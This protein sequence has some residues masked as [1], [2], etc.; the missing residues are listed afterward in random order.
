MTYTDESM[1]HICIST[2]HTLACWR[3]THL[4]FI[5]HTLTSLHDAYLP[6]EITLTFI[7]AWHTLSTGTHV[8]LYA[9]INPTITCFSDDIHSHLYMSYIYR[10]RLHSRLSL[11]DTHFL[12]GA[13]LH[14]YVTSTCIS[15]DTLASLDDTHLHFDIT[16]T[17]ISTRHTCN[18]MWRT[19]ASL[20]DLHFRRYTLASL[21]DAF[22]SRDYTLFHLYTTHTCISALHTLA[23]LRDTHLNLRWTLTRISGKILWMKSWHTLVFLHCTHIRDTHSYLIWHTLNKSMTHI[24]ISTRH[25]LVSLRDT[26]LQMTYTG[27]ISRSVTY[28]WVMA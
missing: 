2:W 3:D 12:R 10:S 17:F 1:T 13:H 4:H 8:H 6:L 9:T 21:D 20:Q 19:L 16:L 5:Q 7:S 25:T 18:S 14:L 24:C 26:Q 11:H 28:D 15:D 27:W 23:S 22:V